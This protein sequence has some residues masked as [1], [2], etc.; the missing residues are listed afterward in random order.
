MGFSRG[1]EDEA[2]EVAG[3][4]VELS[5]GGMQ[6]DLGGADVDMAHDGSQNGQHGLHVGKQRVAER[7]ERLLE[8]GEGRFQ[9]IERSR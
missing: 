5:C 2:V 3:G 1:V 4:L 8:Q 9:C 7:L 6:V